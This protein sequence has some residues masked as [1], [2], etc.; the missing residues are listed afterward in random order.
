MVLLY[1]IYQ[2]FEPWVQKRR[3]EYVRHDHLILR[4]I[5]DVQQNTLQRFS[6]SMVLQMLY[7]EIDQDGSS[8]ISASEIKDLLLKNKV[9]ETNQ[10]EVE[11]VLQIFDRNND[12][13][14]TKEEFVSG[15]AKWLDQTKHA[16][17]KQY[18]SRKS[19]KE[20]YQVFGPWIEN[21]RKEHEG[22]KQLI[23]EILRHVQIDMV[24]NL[25]TA[26]GKPD[27]QALRG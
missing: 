7:K 5:N 17:G 21:K 22:K 24:G 1:F 12:Q 10:K 15:F 26:D 16:L 19:L 18:F 9:N 3:L 2:L 8:G 14:I 23:T 20:V 11:D 27:E 25:L 4:I 13:K 6:P